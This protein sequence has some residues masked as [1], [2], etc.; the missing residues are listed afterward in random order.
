MN[1]I[2]RL[3]DFCPNVVLCSC[4]TKSLFNDE[5]D[6]F[7]Y[8]RIVFLNY[9]RF[10][11][12]QIYFHSPI[13]FN[14]SLQLKHNQKMLE[15]LIDEDEIA[16]CF[17]RQ[18]EFKDKEVDNIEVEIFRLFVFHTHFLRRGTQKRKKWVWN[19]GGQ[20]KKR[21]KFRST[22]L[23]SKPCSNAESWCGWCL[24]AENGDIGRQESW[25]DTGRG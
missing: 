16:K 25:R 15:K 3:E 20:F 13:P 6:H 9:E 18:K 22:V 21:K 4:L 12:Y 19:T 1:H 11:K 2:R 14:F 10:C 17:L 5:I 23:A 8:S 24:E 7:E